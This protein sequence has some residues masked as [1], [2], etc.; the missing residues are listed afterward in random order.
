MGMLLNFSEFYFAYLYVTW[1]KI[2]LDHVFWLILAQIHAKLLK[3]T[4]LKKQNWKE[5]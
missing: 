2:N 3:Y 1:K 5:I 4:I